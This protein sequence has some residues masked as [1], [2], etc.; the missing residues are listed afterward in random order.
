MLILRRG[1]VEI[2]GCDDEHCQEDSMAR[3]RHAFCSRWQSGAKA[4]KVD[5]S[6]HEGWYL[7]IALLDENGDEGFQRGQS[8]IRRLR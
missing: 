2:L 7:Y 8:G 5:K 6:A 4:F 1:V 3:A